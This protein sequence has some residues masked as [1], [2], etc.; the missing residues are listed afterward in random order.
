M[1]TDVVMSEVT[2]RDMMLD[3]VKAREA[4]HQKITAFADGRVVME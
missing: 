4:K 2:M 3:Y 1:A